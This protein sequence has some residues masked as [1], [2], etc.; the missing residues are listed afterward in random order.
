MDRRLEFR[1]KIHGKILLVRIDGI[2]NILRSHLKLWQ[3]VW[4]LVFVT[5]SVMSCYLIVNSTREFLKYPVTTSYR[6]ISNQSSPFPTVSICNV[7]AL[8]SDH[9]V[10]L[11]KEANLTLNQ[12]PYFN[13]M[14]LE[15]YQM[16]TIGRYLT[17]EEK[18]A[19]FDMDG[20][21]ISCSFLNKPCNM[22]DF[23]YL[24][25]PYSTNCIQFNSGFDSDGN[26]V[27]LR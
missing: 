2:P 7:N 14:F 4:L 6:L 26:S 27:E 17:S 25:L 12:E 24:P 18:R 16:Q 23:R 20:F 19:T 15:Q 11:L 13:M 9:F 10:R 5:S 1:K 21:I 3:A 22:S 8:N